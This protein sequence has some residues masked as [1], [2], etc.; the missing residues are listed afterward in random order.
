MH[1]LNRRGPTSTILTLGPRFGSLSHRPPPLKLVYFVYVKARNPTVPF[2]LLKREGS[3]NGT[4]GGGSDEHN[5]STAESFLLQ[6]ERLSKTVDFDGQ[7]AVEKEKK[8][9]IAQRRCLPSPLRFTSHS[10]RC[11]I[12]L[13]MEADRCPT[14]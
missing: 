11:G 6:H 14:Y 1:M 3:R 2:L 7:E 13:D 8:S 12:R 4:W 9:C 5:S 10:R